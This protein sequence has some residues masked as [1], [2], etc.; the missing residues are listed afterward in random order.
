MGYPVSPI[1]SAQGEG[2]LSFSGLVVLYELGLNLQKGDRKD[3]RQA[4]IRLAGRPHR[5]SLPVNLNGFLKA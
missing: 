4:S 3:F 1:R 2:Y 5:E